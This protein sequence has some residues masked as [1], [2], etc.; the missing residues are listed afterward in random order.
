MVIVQAF[1]II[2]I[3]SVLYILF[4][5]GNLTVLMLA[6]SGLLTVFLILNGLVY[7]LPTIDLRI[8]PKDFLSILLIL[9]GAIVFFTVDFIVRFLLSQHTLLLDFKYLLSGR[10]KISSFL[11][12]VVISIMEEG[13]FRYYMFEV[14]GFTL[15][16]ILISSV[17]FGAV[18][19]VFSRYDLIS[20]MVLGL[21]CGL[22]YILT[23]NLMHVILFHITY[24]FF[25]LRDRLV[26]EGLNERY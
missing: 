14:L 3:I 6:Y 20:K 1:S 10:V 2:L 24:N 13:F 9:V 25:V 5:R 26:M 4:G 21:F 11:I 22:I 12:G 16:T 15:S 7:G 23:R 8:L 18:H 17:S 19:L